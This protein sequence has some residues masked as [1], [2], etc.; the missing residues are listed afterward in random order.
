MSARNTASRGASK[1]RVMTMSWWPGSMT[2]SVSPIGLSSLPA[3]GFAGSPGRNGHSGS[4]GHPEGAGSPAPHAG[5]AE[6]REAP[7]SPFPRLPGQSAR[8]AKRVQKIS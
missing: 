1:T 4:S 5:A 8:T 3:A 6:H 2:I 7:P